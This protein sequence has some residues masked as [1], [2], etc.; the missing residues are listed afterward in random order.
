MLSKTRLTELEKGKYHE[1]KHRLLTYAR[2][3]KLAKFMEQDQRDPSP[4]E[5]EDYEYNDAQA[6]TAPI[7]DSLVDQ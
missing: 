3:Q 2:A 4:K 6:F 7:Y 5:K 1:W